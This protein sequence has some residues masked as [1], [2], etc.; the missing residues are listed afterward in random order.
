MRT[1]IDDTASGKNQHLLMLKLFDSSLRLC[2]VPLSV[3]TIWITVTNQ[4]DNS[5]YGMLKYNNLSGLKYMVLVSALCASYAL[6]AAACSWVRYFVSKAWIFFVSDQIVA[7]LTIT[8]VAAVMEIYYLAYNGA[9]ED[10]WSQ[11]CSSYGRFCSKVKLV[12]ILH[13]IT[14]FCFFFLAVISAFRAFSVF[15]P[16]YDNSQEVEGD[17]D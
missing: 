15:D 1:H 13:V 7:Y 14:F 12:L 4:Q 17:R 9:K 2:A 8:S 6:V 3:A 5:S 10:S 16:P 11:A